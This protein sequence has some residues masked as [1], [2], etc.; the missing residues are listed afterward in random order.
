M[1][2]V[3]K[4]LGEYYLDINDSRIK[5]KKIINVINE[6]INTNSLITEYSDESKMPEPVRFFKKYAKDNNLTLLNINFL[7]NNLPSTLYDIYYFRRICLAYDNVSNTYK[8]LINRSSYGG[9][10]ALDENSRLSLCTIKDIYKSFV[11]EIGSYKY[12]TRKIKELFSSVN[13]SK[14]L[15][16]IKEFDNYDEITY[17]KNVEIDYDYVSITINRSNIFIDKRTIS[18]RNH[19]ERKTYTGV[20]QIEQFLQRMNDKNL[21]VI[22][23]ANEIFDII[24]KKRTTFLNNI[25]NM[26]D[27]VISYINNNFNF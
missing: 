14:G 20:K 4:I 12:Q 21:S 22:T 25:N 11:Y 1:N 10:K 13:K 19:N 27:N 3:N 26:T 18:M 7:V 9:I 23:N 16:Y 8:I 24:D 5:K 17:V 15:C 6:F 2:N